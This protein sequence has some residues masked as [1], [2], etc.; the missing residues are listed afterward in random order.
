MDLITDRNTSTWLFLNHHPYKYIHPWIGA[1]VCLQTNMDYGLATKCWLLREAY[2]HTLLC[3]INGLW[4]FSTLFPEWKCFMEEKEKLSVWL[5]IYQAARLCLTAT[6]HIGW[7]RTIT[8]DPSSSPWQTAFVL[9]LGFASFWARIH[10]ECRGN[11]AKDSPRWLS[12]REKTK[13]K[14][15]AMG[16]HYL[17]KHHR[18][19][20]PQVV[21]RHHCRMLSLNI[22]CFM[23]L[24]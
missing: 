11:A 17:G 14:E 19:N 21:W 22:Q 7:L 9:S 23:A 8:T 1:K 4:I 13:P 5:S 20:S 16:I 3:L 10:T 6:V 15:T 18:I 12:C 2:V 24:Q